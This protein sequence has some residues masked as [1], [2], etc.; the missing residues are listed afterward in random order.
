MFVIVMI[1]ME[2]LHFD[3]SYV[4]VAAPT[5][6]SYKLMAV[7]IAYHRCFYGLKLG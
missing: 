4:P 5:W 1:F 2:F 3:Y 6:N 7:V